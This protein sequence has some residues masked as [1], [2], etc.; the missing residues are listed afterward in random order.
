MAVVRDIGGAQAQFA[1]AAY[2][3]LWARV[4]E[5]DPAAVDRA[6]YEAR[7]LVRTWAMRATVHLVATRD[8]PLYVAALRRAWKPRARWLAR[9]GVDEVT[10]ERV[11]AA[12]ARALEAGPLTRRGLAERVG[13]IAGPDATLVQRTWGGLVEDA[14]GRGV[15]CVGPPQGAEKTFVRVDRWLPPTPRAR[16]NDSAE[17]WLLRAYLRAFGPATLSDFSY[18][19]GIQVRDAAGI[20]RRIEDDLVEVHVD[21]RPAWVLRED[22]PVLRGIAPPRTVRLLP[23]FDAY[24]L[25]HRDK[26]HLVDAAHYKAVYRNAGWLS[27]ALLVN[28]QVRGTWEHRRRG[29]TLAVR[30]RP[31]APLAR[32]TRTAIEAEASSLARFLG[33]EAEQ[34][35]FV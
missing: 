24:L 6:L 34:V 3:S 5:L 7:T 33:A 19:S 29:R 18:W 28:G 14:C 30:V 25:G 9:A 17:A 27:Q 15:A 35:E 26:A 16:A 13:R 20:A 11:V 31:F 1:G 4:A 23:S 2:L 21:R 12:I 8:L 22:L 10:V 32:A